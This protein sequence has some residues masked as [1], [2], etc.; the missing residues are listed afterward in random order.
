M[1]NIG[2]K[3]GWISFTT[4]NLTI[5]AKLTLPY[6]AFS[7]V[8]VVKQPTA[9][10]R[11]SGANQFRASGQFRAGQHRGVG[12]GGS[13][14]RGGFQAPQH[15]FHP[16][17]G[18][19]GS[20][21]DHGGEQY[22]GSFGRGNYDGRRGGGWQEWGRHASIGGRGRGGVITWNTTSSKLLPRRTHRR[23]VL[24]E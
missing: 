24:V 23:M 12:Q 8:E 11:G 22:G 19:R 14:G 4:R 17:Y 1:S 10:E 16:G 15:G 2:F 3:S 7:Y 20:Y 6:A 13:N 9:M 18:G 21:T 5:W